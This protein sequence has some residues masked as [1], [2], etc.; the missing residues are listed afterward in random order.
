MGA[1][2]WTCSLQGRGPGTCSASWG[3]RRAQVA[4]QS[5]R[6]WGRYCGNAWQ[7]G[8]VLAGGELPTAAPFHRVGP[9]PHTRR[10]LSPEAVTHK[11]VQGCGRKQ[12]LSR[13][14]P[15]SAAPTSPGN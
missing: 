15:G 14:N 9:K 3:H 12:W 1:G 13:C 4:P 5:K 6:R 8:T 2:L 7:G 10:G 11:V